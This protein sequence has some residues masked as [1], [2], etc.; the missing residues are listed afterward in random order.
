MVQTA[1]PDR[2]VH[3]DRWVLKAPLQQF[4]DQLD[5]RVY[6]VTTVPMVQT[7]QL[8]RRVQLGLRDRQVP[9]LQFPDQSDRRVCPVMTGPMA[10]TA[11][12]VRLDRKVHRDQ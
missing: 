7:A 12:T 2:K 6:P 4:Q 8:D 3:R 11:Q 1:Q 9:H 10:Q 5:R